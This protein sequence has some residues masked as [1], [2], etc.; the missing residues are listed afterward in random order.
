M[1]FSVVIPTYNR[2]AFI[3][4]TLESVLSQTYPYYEIIVVDNCSTD[5]TAQILEPYIA[6]EKITFIKHEQN[7]ERARSR[8][9]GM[10]NARGDFLTFLD[11]DDFM[12]PDNLRDAADFAEKNPEYRVFHNLYELV[13][14]N[15][16]TLYKYQF[17]SLDNRLRAIAGGNFM[18]C[19]GNFIHREVYQN[20]R[21]DTFKHLTGGEDWEFWLRVLADFSVGRIEKYNSGVQHHENRSI[22]NQSLKTMDRGLKYM[23]EKFRNDQHLSTVYSEYLDRIEANCYLYLNLLANDG[24]LTKKALDYLRKSF[25]TD[26]SV[27]LTMRFQRSLLRSLKGIA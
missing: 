10:K 8:N 7:F 25:Q 12:Y 17:P 1:F 20:Y 2:E 9:T 22:N 27:F 15:R 13:D 16:R 5:R 18:S 26:K 14:G 24:A 4:N 19:I 6:E 11:S 3:K 21:F 23:V